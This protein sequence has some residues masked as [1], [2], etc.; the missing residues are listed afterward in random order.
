MIDL[1][2]HTYIFTSFDKFDGL[3]SGSLWMMIKLSQKE[4][5]NNV[6]VCY[7][8]FALGCV[9]LIVTTNNLSKQIL[10]SHI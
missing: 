8:S 1:I 2:A 3:I 6:M 5:S 7:L 4:I 10:G 9:S